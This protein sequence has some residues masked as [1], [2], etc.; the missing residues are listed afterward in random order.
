MSK[1]RA[2]INLPF[3][4]VVVI[5]A[6]GLLITALGRLTV[7]TDVAGSLP[8]DDP[9]LFDAGYVLEH[10]PAQNQVVVDLELTAADLDRLVAGAQFVKKRIAHSGLF[11]QMQTDQI[12]QALPLLLEVVVD[13]LPS[14][15]TAEDLENRAAALLEPN[16]MRMRL[17]ENLARLFS[18]QGIGQADLIVKDPLGLRNI[19]LEK[20]SRQS[21]SRRTRLERGFLVSDD[22]RHVLILAKPKSSGTDTRF[23]RDATRLFDSI[24]SALNRSDIA[25]D[26]DFSLTPVGAYRAALDNE[27]AAKKDIRNVLVLATLGIV[28]LLVLAF[29]RPYVGLFALLPALVGTV[30]AIFV[31]ALHHSSISILTLGFGGAIISIT[32]DHGI[33]YLLF[34][35][36]PHETTGRKAAR[37]VWAIG[38]L[39][40]LTS[41]GAFASLATSGFA[42]LSEIGQFAAV[43]IAGSFLFVHTVFPRIFPAMPPAGARRRL[44][45]PTWVR[46]ITRWGG[47]PAACA[48]ALFALGMLFF[49]KPVFNVD[50]R[51]MNTVSP[52]TRNAEERLSRTWGNLFSRVFLLSSADSLDALQ[53]KGDRLARMLEEDLQRG[54]F[55]SAFHAAM[56]LP[57]DRRGAENAAA[58]RAFWNEERLRTLQQALNDVS[59]ELGL[60]PEAFDSFY[61]MIKAPAHRPI[62]IPD[63]VLPLLG[64][65]RQPGNDGPVWIQFANPAPGPAYRAETFYDRY[66]APGQTRLLDPSFFSVKLGDYLKQT[67]I[68]MFVV[69]GL[70][71]LCLVLFFFWDV[72]LAAAALAPIAFAVIA[73]LGTLNLIGHPLDV[74]GLMLSI[75]I[76]GMGIDYALFFTRAHQRYRDDGHPSEV[77]IRTAVFLAAASTLIGFGSLTTAEHRLLNSAGLT[78]FMGIAYA[79]IGTVLILPPLLERLFE[80][81]APPSEKAVDIGSARRLARR[82]FR[83]MEA[84]PRL[85]AFYRFRKDPLFEEIGPLPEGIRS[86]IAVGT[87]YGVAAAWLL[88][89]LPGARIFGVEPD[90]ERA[91]VAALVV[92]ERGEVH[93]RAAFEFPDVGGDA[94]L[95]VFLD[96][97]EHLEDGLL[98]ESL[99]RL[100]GALKAD[101]LGILRVR[102]LTDI[103]S[104]A[105]PGTRIGDFFR[106]RRRWVQRSANEVED[107]IT[108]T[109]Y[110]V[111]DRRLSGGG[112]WGMWFFF[113]PHRQ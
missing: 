107:L 99:R 91:R 80:S 79:F 71:V 21:P 78:C 30:L 54:F 108:R 24:E 26:S 43:G 18:L 2:G 55:S 63:P 113:R 75:V 58:W 102:G 51:E 33:A 90:A 56:V 41:V 74:P 52:A 82:R 15:L 42:I 13:H 32:V 14:L 100:H 96:G 19:V 83:H 72:G 22:E 28:T 68:R 44:L 112:S 57:G 16:H 49:A 65:H 97:I 105:R 3:A 101:A 1:N 111:V 69:I 95:A 4:A 31:Y 48:A 98:E 12:Q 7:E 66:A 104:G 47:K 46:R 53:A 92:G 11:E 36:R 77:L 64:I 88:E 84:L 89:I 38:L 35:D 34:L 73:T 9:I 67:F 29:P 103:P 17:R 106:R 81:S 60:A 59:I 40:T 6:A 25:V 76:L 5:L 109:G 39:A 45:I 50:F 23:A 70:S 94:D 87:G 110:R 61:R 93:C 8:Y 27:T 10:H 62:D 20:L 85:H 86:V 37:E